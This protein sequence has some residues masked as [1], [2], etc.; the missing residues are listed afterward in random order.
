MRP[1]AAATLAAS[2][3]ALVVGGLVFGISNTAVTPP[4]TADRLP[5]R[6]ILFVLEAGLAEM[7]LAVDHAGQNVET[8]GIDGLAGHALADRPDLGDAPLPHANIG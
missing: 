1:V 7:H 8:G 5:D 4:N 2:A 3:S 6:Q